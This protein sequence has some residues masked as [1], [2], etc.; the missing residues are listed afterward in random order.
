MS[1]EPGSEEFDRQCEAF[2]ADARRW[3][4][5]LRNLP[6][7][8]PAAIT[9]ILD[10]KNMSMEELADE[11]GVSRPAI[12]KWLDQKRISL[13]H[14]VAICVALTLRADIGLALVGKAGYS[15]RKTDEDMLLHAMVF[16]PDIFTITSA[17]AL[18]E[19]KKLP[20][21][22]NGKGGTEQE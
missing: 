22:A 3:D 20:K 17:N 4:E 5:L 12:Y 16:H 9:M 21:L 13:R 7:E 2:I 15:F 19:K 1:A 8:F 6:D 14:V 11:I 18:L 10:A